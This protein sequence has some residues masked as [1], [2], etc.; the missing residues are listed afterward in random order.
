MFS[1]DIVDFP[2][3]VVTDDFQVFKSYFSSHVDSLKKIKF[4][5]L[6]VIPKM[7]HKNYRSENQV[8]TYQKHFES[9]AKLLMQIKIRNTDNY[10]ASKVR[11]GSFDKVL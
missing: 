4:W 10:T 3:I 8:A 7:Y 5:K 6:I 2:K 1:G 11:H 9:L